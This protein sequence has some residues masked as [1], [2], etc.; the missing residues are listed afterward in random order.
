MSLIRI[1]KFNEVYIR[2]FTERSIDQELSE[3]FK[4]PI[5]NA[6]FMPHVKAGLS[7]GML[8]LYNLN[9]KKLYAGLIKYVITFA[10]RNN[11]DLEI[12]EDITYD[13]GVT[14][15]TVA[16]FA[17]LLKLSS[18]GN[19]IEIRDYQLEAIHKAVNENRSLLLSPTASGKSLILYTLLRWHIAQ[20]R[21]CLIL[22][23]TT[24]LVVQ[25][26][27]DFEDYSSTNNWSV[28]NNCQKLYSGFSKELTTNCMISTWQSIVPIMKSGT[29]GSK[30]RYPKKNNK[31]V[32]EQSMKEWFSSYD[33]IMVDEAHLATGKSLSTIM[34]HLPHVK[35]R[36]GTTGT[37][38]NEEISQLQLEG[39]IGPIHRVISTRELMDSNRVVNLDIKCLIL[40]HPEEIRKLMNKATYQNEIDY[41]VASESRNKFIVNLA[42]TQKGTTLVLFNYVEKQGKVLYK[43][44]QERSNGKTIMYISGEI[45]TDEREKIRLSMDKEENV[46]LFASVQTCATGINIP[47]IENIIFASS[48]KSKIRNLQSIGRGLRLKEGKSGCNLYDIADDLSYKKSINHTLKHFSERVKIYSTEQF[49]LKLYNIELK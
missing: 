47:S 13:N 40:K 32:I 20:G 42:L 44:A 34:E 8:R 27:A 38:Q 14:L 19:L 2:I 22:C 16:G 21:R 23:P 10:E 17:D 15:D 5:P 31:P 28:E 25:L 48:T 41:L 30:S 33:V 43:M 9:T 11:Y 7:D 37:V 4:Y 35:Y 45:G 6:K 46:V 1:E 24:S 12:A 36:V 26:Y 39:I 3:F 29:T 18:K 49:D